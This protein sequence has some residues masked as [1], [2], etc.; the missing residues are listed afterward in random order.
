VTIVLAIGTTIMARN[1]AI[2]RQLPCVETLG[3]LTVICSDKTGTLT[4]NEM[5]AVAFRTSAGLYKV[6]G[7][8]YAPEGEL[9]DGQT[10]QALTGDKA[11][12]VRRLLA[13]LVLCNDSALNRGKNQ[14][15]KEDWVPNGAPTE[16]ALI[17]LGLKA[18]L[19]LEALKASQPRLVSVP[20]ESE[21]KFM[22]T[23]H[24]ETSPSGISQRVMY[25]KGAPDRLMP[26]CTSQV[27]GDD[28]EAPVAPLDP[29]LW[30]Q[31]QADL[32]SQGL[33]VLAL[34]R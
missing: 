11:E 6:G 21:H 34:C 4:K 31:S 29:A 25:V 16:V 3:S 5:T 27:T 32:S 14:L 13:G 15:G 20:F 18:G 8:G 17:T 23:I 7:V 24:S 28:L 19:Q 9:T 12:S 22:A 33:R 10:G 2:I 30:H 1:N 26:L